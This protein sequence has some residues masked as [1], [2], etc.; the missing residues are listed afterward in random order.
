VGSRV[1]RFPIDHPFAAAPDP[2]TDFDIRNVTTLRVSHDGNVVTWTEPR[3]IY[4]SKG[5]VQRRGEARRRFRFRN[6]DEGIGAVL[7]P[8]DVKA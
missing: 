2:V 7:G 5:Y 8:Y 3:W 4:Q 6:I 1:V